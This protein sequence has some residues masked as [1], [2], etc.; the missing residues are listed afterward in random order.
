MRL[1]ANLTIV[2]GTAVIAEGTT[3][4]VSPEKAKRLLERKLAV[5]APEAQPAPAAPTQKRRE[6]P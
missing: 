2:V 4:D 5:P 1:K 3:F 6:R